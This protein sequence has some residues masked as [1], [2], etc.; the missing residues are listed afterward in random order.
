MKPTVEKISARG[1]F[2]G[3]MPVAGQVCR[4]CKNRILRGRQDAVKF[5][6]IEAKTGNI[7]VVYAHHLCATEQN[8]LSR[9]ESE[10]PYAVSDEK[11]LRFWELL[12]ERKRG[13]AECPKQESL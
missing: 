8:R 12:E 5:A 4:L 13:T 1:I 11:T 3:K 9:A 7:A 10:Q 6:R 2:I